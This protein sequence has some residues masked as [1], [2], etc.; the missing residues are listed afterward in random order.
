M[1]QFFFILSAVLI[2]INISAQHLVYSTASID[3][4]AQALKTKTYVVLLEQEQLEKTN[5]IYEK[6]QTETVVESGKKADLSEFED[7]E[8]NKQLKFGMKTFWKATKFEFIKAEEFE[9]KRMDPASSFIFLYNLK[10]KFKEEKTYVNYLVFALGG[11]AKRIDKMPWVAAVPLSY[12]NVGPEYYTYKIAGLI[13][14]LQNLA[15]YVAN[16]PNQTKES[17]EK[18]FNKRNKEVK[19]YKLYVL[20]DDLTK[21]VYT[22]EQIEKYYQGEVVIVDQKQIEEAIKKQDPNIA[23]VHKAGP[24]RTKSELAF[25]V[26]MILT[27]KGGE[28]LYIR[29]DEI[30]KK[31]PEGMLEKDFK[32]LK[33]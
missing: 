19:D 5:V 33:K 18:Y 28:C 31:E 8:F 21:S 4:A 14:F 7:N 1:K 11:K 6:I 2:S 13:Q 16:N 30:W 32:A 12:G 20:A 24:E 26:K 29:E 3:Q 22:N 27:A 9:Q 15:D 17:I 23:Y 10:T 25:N